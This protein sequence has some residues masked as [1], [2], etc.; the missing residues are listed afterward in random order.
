MTAQNVFHRTSSHQIVDL[1]RFADKCNI[2]KNLSTNFHSDLNATIQQRCLPSLCALPLSAIPCFWPV[3]CR[4]AMIPG[5][6]FTGFA[7]FQGISVNDFRIPVGLQELVQTS[8]C[9][10]FV[11]HGHAYIHWVA[12]FCT[13]TA[14]R[15]LFRGSQLSL[16]ASWSPVVKS[17]KFT[18]RGTASSLRLLHGALVILVRLQISQFQSLGKWV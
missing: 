4:R 5:E 10:V 16:R 3:W 9:E 7:E 2:P 14:C 6:I 15:W 12:K 11:L 1:W 18:A 17:P 8:S 13:T